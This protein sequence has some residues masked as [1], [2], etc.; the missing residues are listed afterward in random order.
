M[1]VRIENHN[2]IRVAF[3]RH[4]GPYQECGAAWASSAS[5][6]KSTAYSVQR[7]LRIGIGHDNPKVTSPE[8]L[9]YDACLTVNNQFQPTGDIEQ[10]KSL[11]VNLPC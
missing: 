7:A 3:V 1:E 8:R 9:R 4:I 5:S 10:R 6:L 2:P 11:A